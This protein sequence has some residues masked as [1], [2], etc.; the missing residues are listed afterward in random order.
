MIF[1]RFYSID[2]LLLHNMQNAA[3]LALNYLKKSIPHLL[4][5]G[6]FRLFNL[7]CNA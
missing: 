6:F 7:S 3:R 5:E 2:F 4:N 1:Y